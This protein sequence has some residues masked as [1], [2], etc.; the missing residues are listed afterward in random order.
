[1]QAIR[2]SQPPG[3]PYNPQMEPAS[4]AVTTATLSA[5][6]ARLAVRRTASRKSAERATDQIAASSSHCE[7]P[8]RFRPRDELSYGPAS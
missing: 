2:S 6:S 8:L 1:M 4:R 7:G 5:S 3:I